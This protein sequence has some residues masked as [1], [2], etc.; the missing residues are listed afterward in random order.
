LRHD[1]NGKSDIIRKSRQSGPKFPN[2]QL[3]DRALDSIR[4]FRE[5]IFWTVRALL[6]SPQR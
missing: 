3:I 5:A 2:S 1:I 4:I 6:V